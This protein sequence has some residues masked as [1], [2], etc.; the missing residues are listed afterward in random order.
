MATGVLISEQDYLRTV[1]DPDVEFVEGT[2]EERYMGEQDHS[3]WQEALILW[4]GN[5]RTVWQLRARPELRVNVA[6]GRYRVPDITLVRN[7]E[8]RDQ[9]LDRPPIA[10]F[11]ILSPDDRLIRVFEKLQEYERM[12]IPNIIIVEPMGMRLHRK[13]VK[14]SMIPCKEDILAIEGTDAFVDW[15]TVEAMLV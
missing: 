13:Y 15:K 6:P 9:I 3:S 1:Y 5:H 11:E 12:G 4:F 8:V 7:D 2:L 10:V 14:G